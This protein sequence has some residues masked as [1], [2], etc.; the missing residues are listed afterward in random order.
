[1][2]E[3][4]YKKNKW[5]TSYLLEGY[6]LD[7]VVDDPLLFLAPLVD[8]DFLFL[9]M[10]VALTTA[11]LCWNTITDGVATTTLVS[12]LQLAA[13]FAFSFEDSCIT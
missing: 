9:L 2:V 10:C 3:Q 8:D 7:V 1:M 13:F 12:V 6:E 11:S 4:L 5:T